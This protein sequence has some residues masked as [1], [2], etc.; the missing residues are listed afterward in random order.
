VMVDEEEN[1]LRALTRDCARRLSHLTATRAREGF[2]DAREN[3]VKWI[4][5]DQRH[6][7]TAAPEF[8]SQG[9]AD[10]SG[11]AGMVC[12]ATPNLTAA[13]DAILTR[14]NL[15]VPDQ[16]REHGRNCARDPPTRSARQRQERRR[17]ARRRHIEACAFARTRD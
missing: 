10:G 5:S 17:R 7:E 4:H 13:T 9:Q 1:T 16:A 11:Q 12:R 3:D 8:L 14:S 15:Q 6:A 2:R